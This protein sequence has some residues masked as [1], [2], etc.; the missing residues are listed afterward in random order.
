MLQLALTC[1][2]LSYL[3]GLDF[4]RTH[5]FKLIYWGDALISTSGDQ[6]DVSMQ[7]SMLD[8]HMPSAGFQENISKGGSRY[9]VPRTKQD[10]QVPALITTVVKEE[11]TE[12]RRVATPTSKHLAQ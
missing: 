7:C 12:Q 8:A 2:L 10:R 9:Q 11:E 5:I 4:K 6:A 3:C 1:V